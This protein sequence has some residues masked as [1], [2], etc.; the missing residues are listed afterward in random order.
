LRAVQ[1]ATYNDVTD[2]IRILGQ[3]NKG[4][5]YCGRSAAERRDRNSVFESGTERNVERA[6]SHVAL[7][8]GRVGDRVGKRRSK[9]CGRKR[10]VGAA[11][12]GDPP[13]TNITK[14][15]IW[16]LCRLLY[17]DLKQ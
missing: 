4:N 12:K 2:D 14:V 5:V 7:N 8:C 17:G 13:R 11:G 15:G 16:V 1:I 6:E 3:R 9:V 10:T